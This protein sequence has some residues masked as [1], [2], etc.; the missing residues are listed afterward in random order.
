MLTFQTQ[1]SFP[2]LC[3]SCDKL[4]TCNALSQAPKCPK[5]RSGNV[6]PYNNPSLCAQVGSK[7]VSELSLKGPE[8]PSNS[9]CNGE[10]YCPSCHK[11]TLVF[12]QGFLLW[13]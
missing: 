2:Y 4:V 1:N 11:Y 3:R 7:S 6:I 8:G 10:Y 5:C 9:L 12:S 13:D